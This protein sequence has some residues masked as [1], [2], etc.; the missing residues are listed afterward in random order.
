[1]D[2][3]LIVIGGGSAG[4]AAAIRGHELGAKVIMIN[5]GVI[6]GTCVN[7]GCVPS[8]T[9]MRAAQRRYRAAHSRFAGIE[10]FSSVSDFTA[11]I[12]QKDDLVDSLLAGVTL[13]WNVAR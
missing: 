1:M 12:G 9:L 13:P 10:S 3:D 4:F 5:D 2:A 11:I 7:F 6:G 8:K